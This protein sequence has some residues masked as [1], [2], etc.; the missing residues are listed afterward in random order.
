MI[1]RRPYNMFFEYIFWGR[2]MRHT[3]S[4]LISSFAIVSP[5]WAGTSDTLLVEGQ[6]IY[7]AQCA[8]CHGADARGDIGSD[9]RGVARGRLTRALKGFDEMPPIDLGDAEVDALAAWLYQL[10]AN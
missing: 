1:V 4:V 7:V 6:E 2:I 9:I 8:E 10:D 3:A 5:A